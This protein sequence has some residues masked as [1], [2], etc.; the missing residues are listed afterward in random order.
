MTL[1]HDQRPE[2]GL[3]SAEW[4]ISS[5]NSIC[6]GFSQWVSQLFF[7]SSVYT[8]DDFFFLWAY[9]H[10]WYIILSQLQCIRYKI[11][12]RKATVTYQIKQLIGRSVGSYTYNCIYVFFF[13]RKFKSLVGVSSCPVKTKRH[14]CYRDECVSILRAV[15]KCKVALYDSNH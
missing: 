6:H 3:K 2:A 12:S 10:G 4:W 13:F 5:P 7:M 11:D 15:R 8:V 14:V 1:S 9:F